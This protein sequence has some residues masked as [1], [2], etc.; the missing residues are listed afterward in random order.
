MTIM[1]IERAPL[2]TEVSFTADD[3]VLVL[4]DGRRLSVPLTWFPRLAGASPAQ[5]RKFELMGD[6]EG[7]HWPELDED[8]S[9]AG[10]LA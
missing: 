10:L 2:A 8:L 6:G 1:V 4:A 7:I 9:V 3:M 5:L